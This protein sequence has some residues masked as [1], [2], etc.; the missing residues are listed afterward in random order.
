MLR[1]FIIATAMAATFAAAGLVTTYESDAHIFV[2]RPTYGTYFYYNGRPA[3]FVGPP[4][5]V[6]SS[7]WDIGPYG[8]GYGWPYTRPLGVRVDIGH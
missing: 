6:R 1:K 2:R 4:V 8:P 5:R 3:A 7:A